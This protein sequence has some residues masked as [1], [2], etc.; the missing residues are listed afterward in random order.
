MGSIS[1][2]ETVKPCFETLK[3]FGITFEKKVIS[4]HRD[5]E[6]LVHYIRDVEARNFKM[7][8]A[9][10]GGAA[11]LA[12]VIAAHTALPVIG[13]PMPS[14]LNGMDSLYSIVQMPGGI[15]VA[16]MAIGAAGAKNAAIFAAQVLAAGGMIDPSL[17]KKY[18]TSLAEKTRKDD[19][20]LNEN[21]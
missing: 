14:A 12:G 2:A 21:G 11:H 4:A 16:T 8:I 15:P 18:K 5:P 13:I 19:A 1:D 3:E 7:F 9:A 6:R 20:K 17:V 10:A